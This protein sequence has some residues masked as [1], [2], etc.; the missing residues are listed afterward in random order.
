[1]PKRI[2]V[3]VSS[4]I[5][6]DLHTGIQRVIKEITR[7]FSNQE[8]GFELEL[9]A[10]KF[11]QYGTVTFAPS[12]LPWL[13]TERGAIAV[14]PNDVR[15]GAPINISA[16]R[17]IL[18]VSKGLFYRTKLS[19][20]RFLRNDHVS[21]F[22][23]G[24]ARDTGTLNYYLT[25]GSKVM[26]RIG[27]NSKGIE[28]L[29]REDDVVLLLDSS[30]DVKNFRTHLE[31]LDATGCRIVSV[32]YDVIPLSHTQYMVPGLTIA[33]REWFNITAQYAHQIVSISASELAT[34]KH[35]V[36]EQAGFRLRTAPPDFSYFHLGCNLPIKSTDNQCLPD[37]FLELKSGEFESACIFLCVGTVEP[38]KN[39]ERVLDGFFQV[40]LKRRDV[41]LVLVGRPGWKTEELQNR[42]AHHPLLNKNIFWSTRLGDSGLNWLYGNTDYLLQASV[43]EGF[44]LPIV[45]AMVAGKP[46]LCSD[47]PV[48]HEVAGD[49]AVYFDPNSSESLCAKVLELSSLPRGHRQI[50]ADRAA[51][52]TWD[53][54]AKQLF[55][56][57][58][59]PR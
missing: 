3:D 1:M 52:I 33:F 18:D 16:L 36:V 28:T 59:T 58:Y 45:E 10:F 4:I 13:A 35:F 38:R 39:I 43:T 9:I 30:W 41:I 57:I 15:T 50:V 5:E 32:L 56:L 40:W 11:T 54:S 2:F 25:F 48:F 51:W 31:R 53:A 24:P 37:H 7:A 47:I 55:D 19:L 17:V 6:H 8:N 34:V 22:L 44:G 12:A 21:H 23:L 42:I 26:P 27:M 14:A 46:I 29:L 20:S 49:K